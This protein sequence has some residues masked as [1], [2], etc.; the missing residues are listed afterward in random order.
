MAHEPLPSFACP[1]VEDLHSIRSVR[2]K[3]RNQATVT[4]QNTIVKLPELSSCSCG[5]VENF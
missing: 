4:I 5:D 3:S 1:G 2:W